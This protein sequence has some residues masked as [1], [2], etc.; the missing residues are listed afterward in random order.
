MIASLKSRVKNFKKPDKK[1]MFW[2]WIGY[3]AVKGSL[4]TAF[5]WIPAIMY[6]L[7]S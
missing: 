4:T 7:N 6:W 3:Q 2:A 1:T 5:I